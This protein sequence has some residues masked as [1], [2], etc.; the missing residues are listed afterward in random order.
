MGFYPQGLTLGDGLF[1]CFVFISFGFLAALFIF[2]FSVSSLSLINT[3]IFLVKLPS[4]I[5]KTLSM[6]KKEKH[7]RQMVFGGMIKNF[8]KDHGIGS[9]SL[10]GLLWLIP[11][12]YILSHYATVSDLDWFSTVLMFT[13]LL[14]CGIASKMYIN[15]KDKNIFNSLVTVFILLTP[16]MLVPGLFKYTLYTAMENMGVRDSHVSVY[17][18]KQYIPLIQNIIDENDLSDYQV[19]SVDDSFS[20]IDNVNVIFTGAGDKSL[21]SLA[22]K[23]VTAN[24]VLPSDAFYT[25]KSQLNHDLNSLIEA[26]KSS[27]SDAFKQNRVSFDYHRMTLDFGSYGY[28]K[29]G[30]SAVSPRFEAAITSTLNPLF[31]V[32]S[33]YPDQIKSL[34][35]IGLS[36][37]EWKGSK[38]DLDAYKYNYDLSVKR[39]L[40][41]SNVLFE[42]ETLQPYGQWLSNKLVIRGELS[43][44]DGRDRKS[45]RRVVIKLNLNQ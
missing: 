18:D 30:E 20:K 37:E 15:H 14:Y 22:N 39:A 26:I 34:E 5:F 36:S 9:I 45:D 38:D 25:E 7:L 29:V 12:V 19:T 35:V 40:A 17:V 44:Q 2:L 10:L 27:S 6:T 21:L 3:L 33:Q 32:L 1:I 41:V 4:F 31:D 43:Q 11:L 23:R 8:I 24:F 16:F 13:P 42:S 28:F